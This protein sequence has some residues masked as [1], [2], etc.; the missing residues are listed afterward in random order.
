MYVCIFLFFLIVLLLALFYY[1]YQSSFDQHLRTFIEFNTDI[2]VITDRIYIIA[3]NQAG[4]RFFEKKDL[5][6]LLSKTRYLSKLI[7]EEVS[8]DNRYITTKTWVTKVDR[9]HPIKVTIS[10]PTINQTFMMRVSKINARRYMI[11]FHNISKALAEKNVMTQIAEKDELT[12]IYNRKK[13]NSMLSAAIREATVYATPFTIILF[14]IDHFKSVNDTYG[15]NVGDK[16]LIQISAL[17]R[18]LLRGDD[19]LARWG[20]EEFIILS[21]STQ[22]NEAYEL[23]NRLRKEIELFP[24]THVKKMT[25]SFGVAEFSSNDTAAELIQKADKALY[26]AK[27]SG[28]NKVRIAQD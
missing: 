14:D 23:A 5:K 4:L 18:N 27:V 22:E 17:V 10:R 20:G 7:K 28:R 24:F 11:T 16:V 13:F 8:D 19:L 26:K 1:Y 6:A 9:D 12:K 25:C 15:H 3:M 2:T 21:P